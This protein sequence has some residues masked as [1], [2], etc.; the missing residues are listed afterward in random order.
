MHFLDLS[1][2]RSLSW[3]ALLASGDISYCASGGGRKLP[4]GR[5]LR[6]EPGSLCLIS[7]LAQVGD[8]KD[9]SETLSRITNWSSA[10][11]HCLPT[12]IQSHNTDMQRKKHDPRHPPEWGERQ[13]QWCLRWGQSGV[14]SQQ[15]KAAGHSLPRSP[16]RLWTAGSFC[17]S[18]P[19]QSAS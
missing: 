14:G 10:L 7:I 19:L 3:S 15:A 16:P 1:H 2:S 8:T 17:T 5:C 18:L 11:S 9:T 13:R 4:V 12:L 6:K